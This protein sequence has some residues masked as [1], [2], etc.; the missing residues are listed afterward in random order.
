MK[1]SFFVGLL[2]SAILLTAAGT[3]N[4]LHGGG[5]SA[6]YPVMSVWTEDYARK[7]GIAVNYQ[8]IGSGGGIRQSLSRT[9]DFG[10]TDKP[11]DHATLARARLAQFPILIIAV[12]P[13]VHLPGIKAGDLFLDGPALAAIYLGRIRR[14]D[15]A[16]ITKL[17]PGVSLP[18]LPIV[19]IHRSDG[20]G[21]TYHFTTYLSEVSP[22][23]KA[24]VGADTAVDWPLGSAAKGN[25]GVVATLEQTRGGIAYVEYAY[26]QQSRLAF[27]G[28][29]N[30][31]GGRVIPGADT[32]RATADQAVFSAAEDFRLNLT[33][34]PGRAGW[35]IMAATYLL[36]RTDAT[37]DTK[38][39]IAGFLDYVFGEGR[40]AAER[41]HYVPL[42][43]AAVDKV[44]A[45]SRRRAAP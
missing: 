12:V 35:P 16:A 36:V 31:D 38:R 19:V 15:D 37:P 39:A 21:T 23:W 40:A 11:L 41:L 25:A 24:E 45:A 10:N 7:T 17:N 34:R 3:A 22:A 30:R 8:T 2:F 13:V 32:F 44:R 27:T 33:D 29:V 20:S 26:A 4:G 9:I 1:P 14:W 42:P 43:A 6:V 28:L 5:G 18:A